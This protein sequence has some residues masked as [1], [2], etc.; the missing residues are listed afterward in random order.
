[1]ASEKQMGFT[2]FSEVAVR[3]TIWGEH[4]REVQ[5]GEQVVHDLV[6]HL[7]GGGRNITTD[8]FFTSYNLDQELMRQNL[9]LVGTLRS[10]HGEIPIEM[11]PSRHWEKL[12][13]IFGSTNNT[14]M[15]SYVP[16]RNKSVEL[17]ST[18]HEKFEISPSE[19]KKPEVIL[20]Y[21]ETK[22]SVDTVDMMARQYSR[23]RDTCRWLLAIFLWHSGLS[24]YQRLCNK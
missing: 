1:M 13:S 12:S 2:Q 7:S 4:F 10:N 22:G 15:V 5:Q 18:M 17:L 21:N 14:L 24:S 11:L 6:D 23:K 9:T 20:F 16:K 19:Q 8:N 3:L